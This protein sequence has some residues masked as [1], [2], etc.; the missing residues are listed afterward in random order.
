[1]YTS[2]KKTQT[3]AT[4]VRCLDHV[5][6]RWITLPAC[7][8]WITLPACIWWFLFSPPLTSPLQIC[9]QTPSLSVR[10]LTCAG[11]LVVLKLTVMFF[12]LPFGGLLVQFSFLFIRDNCHS[13]FIVQCTKILK[14]STHCVPSY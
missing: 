5:V 11:R 2:I 1:M 7:I 6:L 14:C 3:G 12:T 4:V 13:E 9:L 8:W 10:T